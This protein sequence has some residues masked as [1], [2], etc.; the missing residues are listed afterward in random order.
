MLVSLIIL[1]ILVLGFRYGYKRGLI[2]TLISVVGYVVVF[3][4]SLY[5]SGPFGDFL[6]KY[7]PALDQSASN[8]GTVTM[9]FYRVLA[10]W[11]IAIFGGIILRVVTQT[12]TSITKLP[13]IS[14]VNRLA[15]G[16]AWLI[17]FYI[18]V[19]FALLLLTT[20]PTSQVQDSLTSSPVAEF[21]IKET[22]V[23]SKDIWENWLNR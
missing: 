10:F 19:F 2:Q 18:I 16:L 6:T 17:I 4:L 8:A 20:S 7:M 15:G 13:V 14:Q 22:P 23:F 11:I 12:F 5:L 1:L 21:I 3:L 9:I